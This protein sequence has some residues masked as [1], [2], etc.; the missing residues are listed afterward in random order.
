MSREFASLQ[1]AGERTGGQAVLPAAIREDA[2]VISPSK[3]PLSL[4]RQVGPLA[5]NIVSLKGDLA[6]S[7]EGY[8]ITPPEL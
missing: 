1:P 6:S 8:L 3:P 7:Q 4:L 2:L 5:R